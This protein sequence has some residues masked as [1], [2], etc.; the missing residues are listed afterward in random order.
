VDNRIDNNL[1]TALE[2]LAPYKEQI[3]AVVIESTFRIK[4][5]PHYGSS[6]VSRE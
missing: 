4:G 6:S 1:H 2:V 5:S 3:K